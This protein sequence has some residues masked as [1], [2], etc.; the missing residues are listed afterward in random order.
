V[1]DQYSSATEARLEGAER[2]ITGVVKKLAGA[3]TGRE[4]LAEAGDSELAE[5]KALI[6]ESRRRAE[7]QSA[8][9]EAQRDTMLGAGEGR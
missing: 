7:V 5:G 1:F 2:E 3:I 9:V 6:E 8:R 4:E